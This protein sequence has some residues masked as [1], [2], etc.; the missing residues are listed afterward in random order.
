MYSSWIEFLIIGPNR[1]ARPS[2][3][4][5]GSARTHLIFE[6]AGGPGDAQVLRMIVARVGIRSIAL[7][8]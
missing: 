3:D 5:D 4:R 8:G 1:S 6:K 2:N 7:R